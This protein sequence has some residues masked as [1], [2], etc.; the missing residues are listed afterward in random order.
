M[1]CNPTFTARHGRPGRTGNAAA[2][3]HTSRREIDMAIGAYMALR[4]CSE[5]TA[6]AALFQAARDARVGLGA[7]SQ[8]LLEQISD[9]AS[10][11][12]PDTALVYWRKHLT[13]P[14]TTEA[15]NPSPAESPPLTA[16]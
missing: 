16:G 2:A 8:A 13:S 10:A 5:H 7:V 12:T 14:V 11:A 9:V 15:S 1:E 4:R 6:R 3:Q